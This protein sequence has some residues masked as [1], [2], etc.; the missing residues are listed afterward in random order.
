MRVTIEASTAQACDVEAA[1]Q[2]LFIHVLI[3]CALRNVSYIASNI[4]QGVKFEMEKLENKLSLSNLPS[5]HID[6]LNVQI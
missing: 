5:V 3:N 1:Y 2:L 4:G 6:C